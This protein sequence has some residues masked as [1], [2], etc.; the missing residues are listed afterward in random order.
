MNVKFFPMFKGLWKKT[1]HQKAPA[2]IACAK[3]TPCQGLVSAMGRGSSNLAHML[4]FYWGLRND[5]RD[6]NNFLPLLQFWLIEPD[7]VHGHNNWDATGGVCQ[8]AFRN[9]RICDSLDMCQRSRDQH[10]LFGSQSTLLPLWGGNI[11]GNHQWKSGR[12]VVYF[13][14]RMIKWC[15]PLFTR[16]TNLAWKLQ[17]YFVSISGGESGASGRLLGNK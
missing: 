1:S 16:T 3:Q 4:I 9:D 2:L 6:W 14:T 10:G 7:L 13:C 15:L 17:V 8:I 12:Q 5:L 11:P